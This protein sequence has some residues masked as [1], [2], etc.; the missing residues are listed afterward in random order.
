[1]KSGI[2]H[3]RET[4]GTSTSSSPNHIGKYEIVAEIG[5]TKQSRVRVY[6]ALDRALSRPVVLKLVADVNDTRLADRFRREVR[7]IA[8][9][10]VPNLIAIHD[11]AEHEGMPFAAMQDLGENSLERL[12]RSRKDPPLFQKVLLME[13]V[14]AGA[15]E[16][17]R[18]DLAHIGLHPAGIAIAGD[19]VAIIQDFGTV[20]LRS[21]KRT[22]TG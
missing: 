5:A 22:R 3:G 13:Q 8:Q 6:R 16:A 12:I 14:A 17:H 20:R 1:M 19:G 18:A 21:G 10:R 15:A 2:F 7:S 4:G 9:L 11:L